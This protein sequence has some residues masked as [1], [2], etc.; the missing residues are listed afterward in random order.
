[1]LNAILKQIKEKV[2]AILSRNKLKA[3]KY[4]N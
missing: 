4:K 3:L 2:Y 1:M